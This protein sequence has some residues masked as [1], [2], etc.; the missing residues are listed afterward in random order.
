MKQ[1]INVSAETYIVFLGVKCGQCCM[2][3]SEMTH[4]GARLQKIPLLRLKTRPQ[5]FCLF[6]GQLSLTRSLRSAWVKK[7]GVSL[8]TSSSYEA[9]PWASA[10]HSASSVPSSM[11]LLLMKLIGYYGLLALTLT[12]TD[13]IPGF[14]PQ[15][16]LNS[17]AVRLILNF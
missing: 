11:V 3:G 12:L 2:S 7:C 5:N 15:I 16:T 17:F 14:N 9:S 4:I 1:T 8:S 6:F 10:P 13:H